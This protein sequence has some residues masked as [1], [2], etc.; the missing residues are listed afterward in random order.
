MTVSTRASGSLL[1]RAAT[2]LDLAAVLGLA[3]EAELPETGIA[4][5]IESFLVA[6]E[7]GVVIA[8]AGLELYGIDALLRTVVVAAERRGTGVGRSL[9]EAAVLRARELECGSV[10]LLTTTAREFFLQRGFEVAA[11]GSAPPGVRD[12]WEFR[13]G[14]PETAV[15]LRRAT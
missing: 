13:S 8:S 6:D 3:R 9:V 10:Y 4:E 1:I 14:C 12:S 15:F 2:H 7:A 11:R 5:S